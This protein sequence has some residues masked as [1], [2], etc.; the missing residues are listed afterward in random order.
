MISDLKEKWNIDVQEDEEG[1]REDSIVFEID[2]MIAAVSLMPY[3][4]PNGEAEI[5]AENNY[6]WSDAV[7]ATNIRHIS[8]WQFLDRKRMLSKKASCLQNWEQL[9]VVKNMSTGVY[10]SGVVFEPA[11]YEGFADMMKEDKL[12][13]YNWIWF[14][15]VQ[16]ENGLVHIPMA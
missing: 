5:N 13:I 12:P 15:M 14:G 1:K 8:W 7:D 2:D 4:I 6:M 9:A 3:P 16:D 10:T 11:F